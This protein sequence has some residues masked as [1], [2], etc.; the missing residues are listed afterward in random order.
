MGRPRRFDRDEVLSRALDL[1]LAKGY[2][3]ASVQG[4]V[5]ATGVNRFSLYECFGDKHGLFLASLDW[6]HTRRRAQVF[7]LLNG[8]GPK[9]GHIREYF[10]N[11]VEEG[12]RNGPSGCLM[13]NSTIELARTD[14]EVASRAA[15][16]F[17]NLEEMFCEALR[18]AEGQGEI[19]LSRDPRAIARFLLNNSRGLRIIVQYTKDRDVVN[20]ILATLWS[21]IEAAPSLDL[22]AVR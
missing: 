9:M 17:A 5:E 14:P 10:Q 22:Q 16:H 20:D 18:E 12:L 8:P 4:L 1:F 7:A 6:Y 3:A 21:A 11:I 15:E 19:R 2:E 13:V